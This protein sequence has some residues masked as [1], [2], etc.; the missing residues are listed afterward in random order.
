MS[1]R[2]RFV[3]CLIGV[4]LPMAAPLAADERP[5]AQADS[6]PLTSLYRLIDTFP[7]TSRW[8]APMSGLRFE[9]ASGL[10]AAGL[11]HRHELRLSAVPL[12]PGLNAYDPLP[13]LS[14]SVGGYGLDPARATY[15]YTFLER[16]NWSLKVGVSTNMR[17]FAD[18]L[19]ASE[20]MRF[21]SLPLMHV[22]G[23]ARLADRWRLAFDADGVMTPRGRAF[24]I[25][26]RV[27]YAL[28]HNFSLY[29]GWRATDSGGEAE[30]FYGSGFANTA[31]VG[32]R[33]RF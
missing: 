26:L 10:T 29:G 19:R 13:G 2:V 11:S 14:A 7:V 4:L 1:K 8:I 24:D 12:A 22:A 32:V 18:G 16:P 9:A 17:E 25:G 23:D 27:N 6:A 5:D 30:D 15:R 3:V 31:N 28:S 33:L 20:R 21:G